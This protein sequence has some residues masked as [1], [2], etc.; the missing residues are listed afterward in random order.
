VPHRPIDALE[1]WIWDSFVG[2]VALD[3]ARGFYAFE[4]DRGWLCQ[5]IEL[6]PLVMP[7]RPAPY[8]FP[9]LDQR[10]F[11]RLP[12]ML[13]DSLPDRWGNDLIDAKL[14]E[15]GIGRAEITALD[16]LAYTADRGMGALEYR[17]PLSDNPEVPTA[18]QLADLVVA[19][20]RA[21]R[22]E[23]SGDSATQDALQQL[24]QVGTSAGGIRPKA[25]VCFNPATGQVRS[26]HLDP[27]D[28]FEHWIVKLD[29]VDED[30]PIVASR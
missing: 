21:V 24:I 28:G 2:A 4:F 18:I 10:T 25:V 9:E 26:G 5:D 7:A 6:S 17:P 29:G 15:A 30:G 12:A 3:P 23:F 22:G 19:A 8:E 16:R 27:P 13:A 14:A 11:R 1:V 20:R